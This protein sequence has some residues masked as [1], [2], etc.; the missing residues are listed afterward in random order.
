MLPAV[1][2]P[3]AH[4]D[5]LPEMSVLRNWTSVV[6]SAETTTDAPLAGAVHVVPPSGEVRYWYAPRPEPPVS[7]APEPVTDTDATLCHDAEPPATFGADGAVWSSLTV[8]AALGLAGAQLEVKPMPS[9]LR[10]CTRVT[11]SALTTTLPPLVG[12]L[13]VAPLSVEVRY[14]CPVTPLPASLPPLPVTVTEATLCQ[15]VDPPATVGMPG[16]LRSMRTVLAAVAVAGVHADALPAPSMLRI[17]TSVSPSPVTVAVAP[18]TA[19]PQVEPPL[20]ESR[21]W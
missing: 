16:A 10:N 14:S 3:G 8:L 21:Y 15:T 7:T 19:L 17:C 11:P 4:A 18:F 9:M 12:E 5:V 6:P 20:V 13:H 2:E 1:C